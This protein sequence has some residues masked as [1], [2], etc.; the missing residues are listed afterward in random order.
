VPQDGKDA[1]RTVELPLI[2]QGQ[3]VHYSVSWQRMPEQLAVRLGLDPKAQS[4]VILEGVLAE[5]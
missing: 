3:P 5:P 2:M 4:H 1:K